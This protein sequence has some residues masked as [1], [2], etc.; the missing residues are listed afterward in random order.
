M[1]FLESLLARESWKE[2]ANCLGA[3]PTLFFPDNND[4]STAAEA[5]LVCAGCVVRL[6]CAE[7]AVDNRINHGIW[8]GMNTRQLR[9]ARRAKTLVS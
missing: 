2:E 4:T 5:K 6:Q 8:G 9:A 3:N 1:T 7:Y